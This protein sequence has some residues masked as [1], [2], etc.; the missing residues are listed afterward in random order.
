MVVRLPK[1][2][3]YQAITCTRKWML[4]VSILSFSSLIFADAQVPHCNAETS[5]S[6][7]FWGST[8][9]EYLRAEKALYYILYQQVAD[10]GLF[11]SYQ[12]ERTAHTFDQALVL[13]DLVMEMEILK[14]HQQRY[15]VLLPRASNL[16][17]SIV[18]LQNKDG[19][20]FNAYDAYNSTPL[21]RE[22]YSGVVAWIVFA[23]NRYAALSTDNNALNSAQQGVKYLKNNMKDGG[24]I[25][26]FANGNVVAITEANL[27]SWFAFMAMEEYDLANQV[28]SFLLNNLW[29]NKQGRFFAGKDMISGK[30]DKDPYLDNQTLGAHF[31]KQ[32]G[33]YSDAIRTLNYANEN[34]QVKKN[35][36]LIGLDGRPSNM[37]V[38]LGGTCQYIIAKGT[39]SQ[40]LLDNLNK[41]QKADG[42]YPHD[43]QAI[44]DPWH[45][46]MTGISSTVWAHQANLG[47]HPLT[48]EKAKENHQTYFAKK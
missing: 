38:W 43:S 47:T 11:Q 10:S 40:I 32:L 19:S 12:E 31:L 22:K 15:Q 6:A 16:A 36:N 3:I 41:F 18:N 5:S 27:N 17:K 14:P 35:N 29:S 2:I 28:Q 4:F 34:F 42:G 30:V 9:P 33:K 21:T 20:W 1:K 46:T 24:L 45:T 23:L 26:K 39:Y 48:F 44:N 37:A 13:I 25:H 8:K 7:I